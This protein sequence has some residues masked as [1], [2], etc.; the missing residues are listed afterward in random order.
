MSP[1]YNKFGW[2][3]NS[4]FN[5]PFV[6]IVCFCY[7][8][9]HIVDAVL[10]ASW[11][12]HVYSKCGCCSCS[13]VL[14]DHC[15]LIMVCSE[16]RNQTQYL[17][18]YYWASVLTHLNNTVLWPGLASSPACMCTQRVCKYPLFLTF[19]ISAFCL[20]CIIVADTVNTASRMESTSLPMRIQ[21]SEATYSLLPPKSQE[22][23]SL[24]GEIEVKGKGLMSTYLVG[25]QLAGEWELLPP[26]HNLDSKKTDLPCSCPSCLGGPLSFS[27]SFSR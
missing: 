22:G 16:V 18:C 23:C 10:I 26:E 9:V 8:F 7:S 6:L 19:W 15:E 1:D 12:C 5:V 24:R 17:S 13:L 3:S 14:S 25:S 27:T 21:L 11:M 20:F 2:C 4:L